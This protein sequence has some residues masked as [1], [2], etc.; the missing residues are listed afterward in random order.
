LRRLHVAPQLA[1]R[2]VLERVHDGGRNL[3]RRA[4]HV[5]TPEQ[6]RPWQRESRL[7]ADRV[8]IQQDVEVHRARRPLRRLA[9]ASASGLG[10]VMKSSPSKPTAALAYARDTVSGAKCRSSTSSARRRFSRGATLLPAA[11]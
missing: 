2:A 11:T 9:L 7:R 4:Q 3:C 5:G 1:K 10:F 8:S 6:V